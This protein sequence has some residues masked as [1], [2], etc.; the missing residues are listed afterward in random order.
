MFTLYNFSGTK[1]DCCC[2]Y[3]CGLDYSR[4]KFS[5]IN[6]FHL[7]REKIENKVSCPRTQPSGQGQGPT[8]LPTCLPFGYRFSPWKIGKVF[9]TW[10]LPLKGHSQLWDRAD[11]NTSFLTLKRVIPTWNQSLC[12]IPL[13]SSQC[14]ALF[15]IV[16]WK[17]CFCVLL[18]ILKEVRAQKL[19]THR[20]F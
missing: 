6:Q 3:C 13:Q 14:F 15:S 8:P 20:F 1:R 11:L 4:I 5:D 7:K 10:T 2:C 16:Y 19:S 17:T 18:L 12:R 9:Q